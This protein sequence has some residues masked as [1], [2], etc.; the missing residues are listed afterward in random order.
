VPAD[1][2]EKVRRRL[3]AALLRVVDQFNET[4]ACAY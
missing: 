3:P 2:V 4:F 1:L